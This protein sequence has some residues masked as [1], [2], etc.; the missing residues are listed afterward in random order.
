MSTMQMY[1]L[2]AQAIIEKDVDDPTNSLWFRLKYIWENFKV[3][4][5]L[6]HWKNILFSQKQISN[7]SLSR[8]LETTFIKHLTSISINYM[9]ILA[10][11]LINVIS[12]S[13]S[14]EKIK[15]Q[16]QIKKEL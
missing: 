2:S 4:V 3:P 11:H 10:S 7:D 1:K 14:D 15:K 8:V 9:N 6:D 12:N 13:L 16:N 5:V